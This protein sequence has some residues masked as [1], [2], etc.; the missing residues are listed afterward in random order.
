MKDTPMQKLIKIASDSMIVWLAALGLAV[1]I[2]MLVYS[3]VSGPP[4]RSSLQTVEGTISEA[5]RTTQTS[6]RTRTTSSYYEMTLRPVSGAL[7]IKLRVPAIEMSEPDVR[8]LIGR[9]VRAEF[10]TERDVYV[11]STGN[12]EVLT[13]ANTLERRK[14]SFAQYYVDGLAQI[15][16]GSLL[17]LVGLFLGFRKLR[18]AEA[19]G[20]PTVGG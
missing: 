19:A 12:R 10:D 2:G 6:R 18:K 17:M 16:A 3:V 5:S 14:L 15:G 1:G 7:E 20:A 4:S 11:L 8:G 13:Y 9:T